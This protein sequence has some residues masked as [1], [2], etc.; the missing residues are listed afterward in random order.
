MHPSPRDSRAAS[1][2]PMES[3]SSL[4]PVLFQA[5]AHDT[6]K[7]NVRCGPHIFVYYCKFSR[8]C[9]NN[10]ARICRRTFVTPN[11]S[12]DDCRFGFDVCDGKEE[13]WSPVSV[14]REV[15]N[16]ISASTME[17]NVFQRD[18]S[19]RCA[20]RRNLLHLFRTVHFAIVFPFLLPL[21]C[22]FIVRFR[23]SCSCFF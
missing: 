23:T 17:S 15:T 19:I 2:H 20:V 6:D 5:L 21:P 14:A 9:G 10:S 16:S 18:A 1:V 3:D 11:C 4:R 22:L 8:A 13:R 7:L 12:R